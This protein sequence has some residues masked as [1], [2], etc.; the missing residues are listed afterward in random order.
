[1]KLNCKPGRH[2]NQWTVS[3]RALNTP[4]Y[5]SWRSMRDRCLSPENK[6]YPRYGGAG[7]TVCPTWER[8]EQF[9]EDMGRRPIG[10]SLDRFDRLGGYGKEN[11]R[12]ATPLE[13]TRNRGC[14]VTIEFGGRHFHLQEWCD[15][16]GAKYS[17]VHSRIFK[18]GWPLELALFAP[19]HARLENWKQVAFVPDGFPIRPDEGDDETLTW[20]G[21]PEKVT[22]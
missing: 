9:L 2:E 13:Q 1:M 14:A 6:D 12:W 22:A 17:T 3:H 16:Y 21:K 19:P 11:C 7:I 4:E 18:H 5:S 15:L 10:T 20:A 8:F